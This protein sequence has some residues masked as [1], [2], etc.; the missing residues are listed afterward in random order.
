MLYYR[1][2]TDAYDYFNRYGVVKGELLTKKERNSK[3]RYLHDSCFEEVHINRNKTFVNFGIRF[4][5]TE[6]EE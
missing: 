5:K 6:T 1:A 3:C 2:K 4:E